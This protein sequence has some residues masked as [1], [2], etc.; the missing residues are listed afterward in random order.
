[1]TRGQV[2]A[3]LAGDSAALLQGDAPLLREFYYECTARLMR[4]RVIVDYDREPF[5]LD[6]GDVRITFDKNLHSGLNS[7]DLFNPYV[8]TVSPFDEPWTVLEVK[9]DR[10]LPPYIAELLSWAV[11]EACRSAVSKYT[12]CRRF[13]RK[14]DI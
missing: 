9:Y 12:W 3:V 14:D 11:P 6:A 7:I 10:V 1:M 2:E 8:P 5:V 4:P 13:E